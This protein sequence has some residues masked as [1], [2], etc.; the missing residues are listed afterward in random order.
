MSLDCC[1]YDCCQGCDCPA[2][3]A[4]LAPHTATPLITD[5]SARNAIDKPL[6]DTG[7]LICQGLALVVFFVSLGVCL[8]SLGVAMAR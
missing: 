4:R 8:A 2:R 6:D 5:A 3:A 1:T 7:L